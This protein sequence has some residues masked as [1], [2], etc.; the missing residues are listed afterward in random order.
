[1]MILKSVFEILTLPFIKSGQ[2]RYDSN[3]VMKHSKDFV[4]E[5]K[6]TPNYSL[7]LIAHIGDMK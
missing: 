1:M 6:N 2:I 5:L 7:D 4:K 3:H